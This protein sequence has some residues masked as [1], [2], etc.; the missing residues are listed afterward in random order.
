MLSYFGPISLI[1][2]LAIWAA[3]LITGFALLHWGLRLPMAGAD[4]PAGLRGI[5]YMSGS[6]FLT[7]G[8]GDVT[9]RSAG[10][11]ALTVVEAGTGFGFLALVIGYLPVLY[12]AFSRREV[13]ISLLDARAGSPP[14]A[15][16]LLRRYGRPQDAD[17][18]AALFAEWERWS[19]E[20]LES[21]LSFPVLAWYRSQHEQQSWLAALTAVLDAGALV[22]AGSHEPPRS[23][24]LAFAM[25]RHAA[26]DLAQILGTEAAASDR[27]PPATLTRLRRL[28]A[29]SGVA[30]S[31]DAEGE[32]RLA[33]LRALYEPQV[34]VIATYLLMPL[35]P[36]LPAAESEDDW[37]R[38]PWRLPTR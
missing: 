17:A 14:T 1:V 31:L 21:H 16:E 18:L 5:L 22:L 36:W 4:G 35:P 32:R 6:T 7:L 20:L 12:G 34:G 10:G 3:G 27:L 11:R 38:D 19:A 28:L 37:E 29:E 9:A 26:V 15:G 2:L 24:R 25:A 33:A 23:A 13:S 30:L 8:I